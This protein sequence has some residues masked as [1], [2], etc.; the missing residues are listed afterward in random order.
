[1]VIIII[2]IIVI[3]IVIIII[4]VTV[5]AVIIVIVVM[6]VFLGAGMPGSFGLGLLRSRLKSSY[7]KDGG[8]IMLAWSP[9]TI[10]ACSGWSPFANP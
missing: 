9:I 4:I 6:I 8:I 3:V 2:I 10:G 1:M 5:V 7:R